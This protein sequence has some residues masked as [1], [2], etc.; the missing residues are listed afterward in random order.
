MKLNITL[1]FL[2]LLLTNISI[3][4]TRYGLKAGV[5]ISNQHKKIN[6]PGY[7][8]EKIETKPLAGFQLGAF[9]KHKLNQKFNFATELN[10]S[11]L[12]SKTKYTRTDFIV[13][14]NGTI[15]GPI[16]GYYNDNIQQ[17]EIPIFL[18]YNVKQFYLGLGPT[19]GIKIS[20]RIDNYQNS[21]FSSTYYNSLDFGASSIIGYS[22]QKKVDLAL[23]YNYGII[24]TDKRDHSIINNRVANFSVLYTL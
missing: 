20:S 12:G 19:I 4:Q 7:P 1:C 6:P 23:K 16:T 14:P 18:Q 24:N 22:I 11:D 17:I 5:N 9:L 15:S 21:S 13:N 2:A 10:F 3:G 8:A